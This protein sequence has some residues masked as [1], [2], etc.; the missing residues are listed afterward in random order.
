MSTRATASVRGSYDP[1]RPDRPLRGSDAGVVRPPAV[2]SADYTTRPCAGTRT[3]ARNKLPGLSATPRHNTADGRTRPP[4]V[5]R[6]SE[7]GS[8]A[9][10]LP[11]PRSDARAHAAAFGFPQRTHFR[12]WEGQTSAP[13][14]TRVREWE[15]R[16][17]LPVA[18]S[19]QEDVHERVLCSPWPSPQRSVHERTRCRHASEDRARA[20][21]RVSPPSLIPRVEAD[22]LPPALRQSQVWLAPRPSGESRTSAVRGRASH[23]ARAFTF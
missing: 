4:V 17:A 21:M 14:R 5:D 9:E 1:E 11:D 13:Q 7:R 10:D 8:T 16:A 3:V 15:G 12:E 18:A 19:P 23:R 22:P 6:A 2:A 20:E